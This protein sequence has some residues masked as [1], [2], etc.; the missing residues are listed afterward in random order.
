MIILKRILKIYLREGSVLDLPVSG[1]GEEA[2]YYEKDNAIQYRI[3]C[4]KYFG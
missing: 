3:K 2:G 4:Q 1:W